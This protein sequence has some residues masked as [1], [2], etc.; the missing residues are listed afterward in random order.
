MLFLS[1]AAASLALLSTA[2]A[3]PLKAEKRQDAV[4]VTFGLV[5]GNVDLFDSNEVQYFGFSYAN[6]SAYFG[7]IRYQTYSEPL[8]MAGAHVGGDTQGTLVFDSIHSSPTGWQNGY[9]QPDKTAPLQFTV[10]HAGGSVPADAASTGFSFNQA[11]SL[12]W[13]GENKF[14]ACQNP[15]L[16]ALN[17]YQIWWNGAGEFPL[18][19]DC[20]G[21]IDAN[22]VAGC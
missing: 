5:V 15:E 4:D 7:Q 9:I 16:Q 17:T 3:V 13:N 19:I 6:N 22:M 12:V 10:P 11:G 18:G 2:S 14:W 1:T 21:P 8:V 20:K